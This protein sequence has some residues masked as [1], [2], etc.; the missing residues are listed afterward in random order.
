MSI[1]I[2]LAAVLATAAGITCAATPRPFTAH[3]QVLRSGNPLGHAEIRL[4]HD[5]E[6]WVLITHTS[7]DKGLGGLL[8]LDIKESSRFRI[9]GLRTRLLS[10]RYFLDAGF[11]KRQRKVDVDW[12]SGRVRVSS[13]KSHYSYAAVPGLVDRHLLPLVLGDF[14]ARGALD[15]SFPVAVKDRVES[16]HYRSTGTMKVQVPI[17]T[18]DTV[19]VTRSDDDKAFT[20]WYAPDRYVMPVKLMHG[21]YILLLQSW[22]SP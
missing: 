2:A 4:R 13:G 18:L 16:Q 1:R 22:T 15:A 7:A 11:R 5:G 12:A 20:A 17:G 6:D 14:L 9:E 10:Y 3:Y 8:G 21:E 19:R